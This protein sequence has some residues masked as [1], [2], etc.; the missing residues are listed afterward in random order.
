MRQEVSMTIRTRDQILEQYPELADGDRFPSHMRDH[1]VQGEIDS[2]RAYAAAGEPPPCP[3]WCAY[4]AGHEYD[5]RD[6]GLAAI[7]IH[8]STE[9]GPVCISQEEQNLAGIVTLLQPEITLYEVEYQ[10][11]ATSAKA[12]EIAAALLAIA[13]QYDEVQAAQS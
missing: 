10:R 5:S 4:L 6:D 2:D 12:R 1:I 8:V 3:Q 9:D 13:D 11:H 7:R